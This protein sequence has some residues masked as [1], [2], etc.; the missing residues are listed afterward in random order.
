MLG[1]GNTVRVRVQVIDLNSFTLDLQVPTYLPAKDLT[2]RVARDAGLEAYGEDGKR[3][4][5]WLRARGR[6]IGPEEKLEDVG[7]V[8]G[9][10]VYLLPEPP[11]GSV[12]VEQ[13]PDYPVTQ[14]YAGKGMATV[15]AALVGV[16][17]WAMAWGGA[18][19]VVRTG[20][21]VVM[22]G[23]GMGLLCVSLARH[24]WGGQGTRL[25]VLLTGLGLYLPLFVLVFLPVILGGEPAGVVY[26]ESFS[27]MV[28]GIIAVLLGWAAWW[29]AVEPLPTRPQVA[30]QEAAKVIDAHAC[31]ICAL[32]VQPDYRKDCSY[33]CGR[34][35]HSGCHDT[36]MAVNRPDPRVCAIC[37]ARI[38]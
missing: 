11:P 30:A 7:V 14:G 10:L 17:F 38:G 19:L 18:L 5:Y 4:N 8:D 27:G 36:R 28:A 12:V 25:R 33:G 26:Q 1:D 34:V 15:I 20:W 3:R 22:P 9:E 24:M 37:E 29:G 32:A 2:V 35:F 16:V 23:I 31:G 21:T 6:L 13:P